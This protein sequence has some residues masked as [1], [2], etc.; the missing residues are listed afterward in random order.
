VPK[1]ASR[2]ETTLKRNWESALRYRAKQ[3][4]FRLTKSRR[5]ID[6]NDNHGEFMLIH[7][8]TNLV[9][10]GS[11]YDATLSDI[12]AFLDSTGQTYS[13]RRQAL[14]N[15]WKAIELDIARRL[16]LSRQNPFQAAE[17]SQ[18]AD[19]AISSWD[20]TRH[21]GLPPTLT[22]FQSLLERYCDLSNSLQD[23]HELDM[24]RRSG[25]E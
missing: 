19:E 18:A 23:D 7:V 3:L 24:L 25:G 6:Y 16:K 15:A 8:S 2:K 9:V 13:E 4:G 12:A 22:P 20:E 10:I 14:L 1:V 11:Q 17:I 21:D 5:D